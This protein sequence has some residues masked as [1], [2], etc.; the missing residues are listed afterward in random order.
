[1]TTGKTKQKMETPSEGEIWK[2][3]KG[4]S[5]YRDTRVQTENGKAHVKL[6]PAL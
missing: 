2:R 5:G 4:N 3:Q 6:C 1:M